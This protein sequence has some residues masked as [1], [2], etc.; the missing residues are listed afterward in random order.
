MSPFLLTR[1]LADDTLDADLRADVLDGLSHTPKSLPPK[2]LYDAHG[3]QLFEQITSTLPHYYPTR[4]E[5]ELLHSHA[6][7][8]GADTGARTLIELG[9]GS[10][11]K[12]RYLL[13]A[14]PDLHSY[15]AVDVSESALAKAG[16]A[17]STERPRLAVHALV[18]DFSRAV[19]LPDT[20]GPRLLAFLGGTIGNFTPAERAD[21]LT[22]VRALLNPGDAFLLGMDL[23]KDESVLIAAYDDALTG[24]FS[25]NVLTVINRELGADFALDTFAHVALWNR[26]DEWIELRLRSLIRQTVKIPALDLSID[27][28]EGEDLRTEISAKFRRA[29]ITSELATAGMELSRWWTT[30]ASTYSLALARPILP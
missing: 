24:A 17:L 19:P 20:P 26:T 14:L 25:K 4:T 10:S 11:E 21:F 7:S 13:D 9:S 18:A 29:G 1:I 5:R 12:T 8:I 15:V 6:P 28:A 30:D 27:F 2:W 23:V 16:R 3:S 22:S